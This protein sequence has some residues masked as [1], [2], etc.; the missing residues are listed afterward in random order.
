MVV[1][2]K[3]CSK[4][5]VTSVINSYL[6]VCVCLCGVVTECKH[7]NGSNFLHEYYFLKPE[8]DNFLW[9]HIF[10]NNILAC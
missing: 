6:C 4:M 1:N 5:N 9:I 10:Q 2:L 7:K 8:Q 3:I